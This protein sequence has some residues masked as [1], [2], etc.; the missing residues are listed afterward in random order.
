[1]HIE[2][3]YYFRD[4][5]QNMS[6]SKTAAQ[7]YMTPQGISRAIH[8]L[9]KDFGVKLTSYQNNEIS[10]T[11][12]GAELSAQLEGFLDQFEHVKGSLV[13]YRL[14]EINSTS[15]KDRKAVSISVTPC[16]SMYVSPLLDVQKPGL[17]DFD[18][19]FKEADIYNIVP[20]MTSAVDE[21]SFCITSIPS[22]EKFHDLMEEMCEKNSLVYE[23]LFMAPLVLL[24]SVYSPLAKKK[25]VAP[26]DLRGYSV[27]RY[28]DTVLGD[29]LDDFVL[30]DDIKTITN[31]TPVINTRIMEDQAISFAPK[32]VEAGS[33]FLPDKITT[34]PTEGFFVTEFG[35]LL[36]DLACQSSRV[37]EVIAYLRSKLEREAERG[38]FA[39]TFTLA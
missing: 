5:A 28:Q 27:A 13:G 34:V 21:D 30:E 36:D 35:V 23:P 7:Y 11:P 8:Q 10:L 15:D 18:V 12:A 6:I 1:M 17:F 9:E 25:V 32:L 24:V 37:R 26:K 33:S 38:R 16:V 14:A 22:T 2:Y 20:S 39:G 4:F 19:K 3:L 29:A 31:A